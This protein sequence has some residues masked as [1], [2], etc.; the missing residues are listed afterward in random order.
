MPTAHGVIQG[1]SAQAVVDDK[2][3][4]ILHPEAMG[5]G[6]DAENLKP[7]IQVTKK[8][9]MAIGKPDDCPEDVKLKQI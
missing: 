7:M 5:N 2:H 6:Q 1:Y 8:N 9:L 4:I 3:Q